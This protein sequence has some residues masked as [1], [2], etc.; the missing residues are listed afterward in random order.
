MTYSAS[1]ART[2]TAAT[3]LRRSSARG[4]YGRGYRGGLAMW[5]AVGQRISGMVIYIFLLVHVADNLMLRVSPDAYNEVI[6][7]Y[8]T[9]VMAIGEIGLVAALLGHAFNG[10]RIVLID[11]WSKGPRYARPMLWAVIALWAALMVPFLA[12]HLSHYI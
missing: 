4:S 8:K 9:I 7:S 11:L 5:A 3:Q 2:G 6:A 1:D 12:R 10:I